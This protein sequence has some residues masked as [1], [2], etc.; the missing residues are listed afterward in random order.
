MIQINLLPDDLRRARGSSPKALGLVFAASVLC[1]GGLGTTGFLW[2]NVRAEKQARVDI[3]QEQLDNLTPRAGY[4]DT[5]AKEKADFEK[6]NKTIGEIALSRIVWTRKLDR[7][8]EIIAHDSTQRRHRVW[9]DSIDVDG[10]AESSNP[11]V[12][13]KGSSAGPD[14]DGVSNFHDELKTDP[15]FAEG[16]T[17]YTSPQSKLGDEDEELEPPLRRDF[18]FEIKLP[19]KDKKKA[20]ARKPAPA[21]AKP[22]GS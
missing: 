6:R 10:A 11:G 19:T 9:L 20:P 21:P 2:F 4:A 16:F 18:Q 15:V 12:K 22:A 5:L 14:L 3:A 7:L 13:L 17:T 8:G 1:F